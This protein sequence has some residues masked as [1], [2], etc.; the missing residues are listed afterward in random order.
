MPGLPFP[1][2]MRIGQLVALER[3]AQ[4]FLRPLPAPKKHQAPEP[5]HRQCLC[6][7]ISSRGVRWES[8]VRGEGGSALWETGYSLGGTGVE[9]S[10][11]QARDRH[12][13]LSEFRYILG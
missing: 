1:L 11:S 13:L 9:P 12:L 10:Q 5:M 6:T 8:D 3:R 2:D 7:V 4:A